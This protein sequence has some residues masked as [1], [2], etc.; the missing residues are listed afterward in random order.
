[1]RRFR[2][3][4]VEIPNAQQSTERNEQSMTSLSV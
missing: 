4:F 1:M 3:R 2:F